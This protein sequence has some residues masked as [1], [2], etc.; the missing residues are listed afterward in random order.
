MVNILIEIS[1]TVFGKM[2][3]SGIGSFVDVMKEFQVTFDICVRENFIYLF[4]TS[5]FS[6]KFLKQPFG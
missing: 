6:Q 1:F 2:K 5:D 4:M 3:F